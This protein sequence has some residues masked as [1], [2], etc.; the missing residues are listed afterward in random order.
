M[1]LV[2]SPRRNQTVLTGLT[3]LDFDH[4]V[5]ERA[6]R[7]TTSV[8]LA[9][10]ATSVATIQEHEVQPGTIPEPGLLQVGLFSNDGSRGPFGSRN[11]CGVHDWILLERGSV[12]RHSC[13]SETGQESA[14]LGPLRWFSLVRPVARKGGTS[15]RWSRS[16]TRGRPDEELP[17]PRRR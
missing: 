11:R 15:P 1:S 3:T 9:I 16:D 5:A 12:K 17:W 2:P 14:N 4:A 10:A 7:D 13:P 8:A 6:G